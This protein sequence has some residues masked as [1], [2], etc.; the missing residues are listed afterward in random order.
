MRDVRRKEHKNAFGRS[1]R[2]DRR[3]VLQMLLVKGEG[4]SRGGEVEREVVDSGAL[5]LFSNKRPVKDHLHDGFVLS[6]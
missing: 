5:F 1:A 6:D 2:L 4:D 3:P